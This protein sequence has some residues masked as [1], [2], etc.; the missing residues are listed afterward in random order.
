MR[1][2]YFYSQ[3]DKKVFV[4]TNARFLEDDYMVNNRAKHDI[5]W[6]A[7]ENTLTLAQK[8]LGPEVFTPIILINFSA[9]M[10]HCSGRIVIQLDKFMYLG[11][12]FKSILEKHEFDP[13]DY[14]KV[15]SSD[16]VILWKWAMEV[17]LESM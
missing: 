1:E 10:P 3:I 2:H 14:E 9:P 6:K 16:D 5:D 7:L 4:S 11:E 17:E 13:L 15:M 8:T 12:S